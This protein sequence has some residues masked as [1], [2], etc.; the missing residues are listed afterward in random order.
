MVEDPPP[1]GMAGVVEGRRY[2]TVTETQCDVGVPSA[3]KAPAP[4]HGASLGR[5]R[6]PSRARRHGRPRGQV[7]PSCRPRTGRLL[8]SPDQPRTDAEITPPYPA[9]HRGG[10]MKTGRTRSA[11]T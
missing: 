6:E 2:V 3:N 9:A 8:G 10:P 1:Q 4:R 5:Q 11:R 7:I